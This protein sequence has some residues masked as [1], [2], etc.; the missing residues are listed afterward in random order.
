MLT[1]IIVTIRMFRNMPMASIS[2]ISPAVSS[3]S[4][5]VIT[6]ARRVEA[7]VMPTENATSP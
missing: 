7:H 3:I 2:I 5:G 1:G 6:G 4:N